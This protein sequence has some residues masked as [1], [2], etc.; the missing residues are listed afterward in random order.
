MNSVKEVLKNQNS[1]VRN[2]QLNVSITSRKPRLDR[3]LA[4]D[5]WYFS[6]QQPLTQQEFLKVW[7]VLNWVDFPEQKTFEKP[8]LKYG[9]GSVPGYTV[10]GK[11]LHSIR[12]FTATTWK[13]IL[14]R[15]E[16]DGIY[17]QNW[18]VCYGSN[19]R[20]C[21]GR[22]MSVPGGRRAVISEVEL[23]IRRSKADHGNRRI[24]Q[25][26]VISDTAVKGKFDYVFVLSRTGNNLN[27][28]LLRYV[29]WWNDVRRTAPVHCPT[30]GIIIKNRNEMRWKP[31]GRL[32]RL[33]V[34]AQRWAR[35][36]CSPNDSPP[37]HISF[38]NGVSNRSRTGASP[39]SSVRLL[40]NVVTVLYPSQP[41]SGL[42]RNQQND[43]GI[44]NLFCQTKR[45]S[46][47][48]ARKFVMW[49]GSSTNH[50]TRELLFVLML[51][52][53]WMEGVQWLYP[54][55]ILV[56]S[57][58]ITRISYGFYPRKTEPVKLSDHFSCKKPLRIMSA[59]AKHKKG[60]ATT[61]S[62]WS[63]HWKCL[64]R[65]TD[66]QMQNT[67]GILPTSPPVSVILARSVSQRGRKSRLFQSGSAGGAP[68]GGN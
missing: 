50:R 67:D 20:A 63:V 64:R 37:N 3:C 66:L 17:S 53:G 10:L 27:Y 34:D 5:D 49:P 48:V 46:V 61:R 33:L 30:W 55:L 8:S 65:I 22:T 52:N 23:S 45:W 42:N 7:V 12:C 21:W 11:V 51:S 60:L 15:G 38:Y 9:S 28:E 41:G 29:Y 4:A 54:N 57:V 18:H 62:T 56:C 1:D 31:E 24:S 43:I 35:Q 13:Y 36:Q 40:F 16:C 14:D 47:R 19:Q 68:A 44:I 2:A 26:W 59:N 25:R 32:N 6:L 39:I 58:R